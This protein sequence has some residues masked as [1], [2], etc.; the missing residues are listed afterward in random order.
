M[1]IIEPLHCLNELLSIATPKTTLLIGAGLSYSLVE[2]PTDIIK[3]LHPAQKEI[4]LN[5]GLTAPCAP[6]N[7]TKS[8]ELYRWAGE[9]FDQMLLQGELPTSA[10][11][12][13]ASAIGVTTNACWRAKARMP[14]RGTTPRHRIIARLAREGRLQTVWSLNWD[15]WLESALTSI[16]IEPTD[17]SST[18][19]QLPKSWITK[20]A[21]WTPSSNPPQEANQTLNIFKPH[22][23]VE[24]LLKG[25]G[26]FILTEEELN[27]ELTKQPLEVINCL[28]ASLTSK[29]FIGLGWSASEGY[30]RSLFEELSSAK[31]LNS[32]NLTIIDPFPNDDGHA[33]LIN[34]YGATRDAAICETKPPLVSSTDDLFLWMQTRY[35]LICFQHLFPAG[36]ENYL[37]IAEW[38]E[39]FKKPLLAGF[40]NNWIMGWFDDFLPV[41]VRLCFNSGRVRFRDGPAIDVDS[42]PTHKRDEHIPWNDQSTDRTDLKAAIYLF[43]TLL[44]IGENR[45][46]DT[47]SFPGALWNWKTQH[48][49]IPLPAW[50]SDRALSLSA[51][52]PLASSHHWDGQGRIQK[53]FILP[54][55][56]TD[57]LA[58]NL[59]Q[60]EAWKAEIAALM[61]VSRWAT[62]KNIETIT[63]DQLKDFS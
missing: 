17:T 59:D 56:C 18:T 22:G 9:V 20:Y 3:R 8:N 57:A 11:L 38:L 39:Y 53:M 15:V 51:L 48:L 21:S 41:W 63:L 12:K 2:L 60:Q 10:K 24:S 43:L 50:E 26:I 33:K 37:K 13:I 14:I 23:C 47:Q 42:I 58:A 35:G 4:E 49:I 61:R 5:L 52:K 16:G 30:L 45:N 29:L 62:A 27:R 36:H 40:P 34:Y 7:P 28:K 32:K 19:S 1:P 54:L 25:D 44:S 55:N 46:L 31:A 6:I